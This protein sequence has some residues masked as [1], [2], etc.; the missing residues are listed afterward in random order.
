VEFPIDALFMPATPPIALKLPTVELSTPER[1]W[2]HSASVTGPYGITAAV[3]DFEEVMDWQEHRRE[4]TQGYYRLIHPPQ[5][6]AFK[7]RLQAAYPGYTAVLFVS[8]PLAEKEW[9]ELCAVHGLGLNTRSHAELPE[10]LEGAD[11]QLLHLTQDE[12]TAGVALVKDPELAAELHERNRRRGGSLSARTVSV[13]LG[14]AEAGNQGPELETACA[15]A[16]CYMENAEHCLFYPS[17]MGAVTAALDVVLRPE[18]PEMLVLGNVY[19]DTHLLLEEQ[20]W[21]GREVQTDFLNTHDLDGL[22]QRIGDPAVAGVLVET[23]TNPLIEIPD[24]PAIA[25]ICAE[26]GKP[27]LVD[28]TMAGPLNAVPLDLGATLVIHSTSK[29]LSGSNT[30]GGG[31]VLTNHPDWAEQLD[32]RQQQEQNRLSSLEFS[33]L[34]EGIQ[35]YPDR[36]F[37]FNRNGEALAKLLRNHPA[38]ETVYYGNQ[39]RP[40]WLK[41]LASVVSCECRN[42]SLEKV[43]RFFD[44]P[45]P[46]VFKAPSL[47]SNQT[48]FCPYVLLAYYDKSEE[49]LRECNL[50]KTLFRFAAGCEEDFE[51]VLK[52]ISD[53]LDGLTD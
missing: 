33:A 22:R 12:L 14:K 36:R 1:K 50:S 41:G 11:C 24:L 19:R 48:L 46:G 44:A 25:R 8:G 31:I 37:R 34:W 17:G 29:Y 52:G 23:I 35:T 2:I 43:G 40:D 13:M 9:G 15:T 53:A 18:C 5:V 6:R 7:L 21:A 39:G 30:H 32:A 26:V 27:L 51:P 45:L 28:S 3:K 38:V 4:L 42:P 20:A 16:L 49:Y 10:T 47:G